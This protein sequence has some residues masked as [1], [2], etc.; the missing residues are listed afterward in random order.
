MENHLS[1]FLNPLRSRR[2]DEAE[3]VAG[4]EVRLLTSAATDL[5][6]AR[7]WKLGTPAVIV[8]LLAGAAIWLAGAWSTHAQL[9]L[10]GAE[11]GPALVSAAAVPLTGTFRSLTLMQPPFPFNP[12]PGLPVYVLADGTFI[13]D[14]SQV[15]YVALRTE[16]AAEATQAK[17]L[18]FSSSSV[19][20]GGG[21]GEVMSLSSSASPPP[22]GGGGG[23][24]SGGGGTGA[25]PYSVPGLKLVIPVL[26]NGLVLTSLMEADTNS[27]YDLFER[28]AFRSNSFWSRI[29]GTD[30]GGTNFAVTKVSTTNAFYLAADTTDS[31]FDGLSD[32]FETLVSKSNPL[33]QDTDGDGLPD[34]DEDFNGNGIPDRFDYARLKRA[35]IFA[36]RPNAF[37]GGQSGELT[38]LLPSPA[39]TNATP[40]TLHLGGNT[41]AGYDY[42]LTSANGVV[43]SNIV[44]FSAGQTQTN[45]FVVASN[46]TVQETRER[47]MQASLLEAPNFALSTEPAQV[48]LVDNDK[49][50]VSIL[51]TDAKAGETV[52]TIQNPG[53][54]TFI[55]EGKITN[56]LSVLVIPGGSATPGVDYSNLGSIDFPAGVD[57]VTRTISPS[58]DNI[59]EGDETVV[60]AVSANSFYSVN[61]LRASAQL[62]IKDA[63][64]P[65]VSFYIVDPILTEYG[66]K[67]ATVAI[68]RTGSTALPLDVRLVIGGTATGGST[69][70]NADYEALATVYTI[71]AGATFID[72][73]ARP[74]A[75]G[76]VEPVETITL[77]LRGSTAYTI[78]AFENTATL[79][80]DDDNTPQYSAVVLRSIGATNASYP[81][82]FEIRRL[83]RSAA[84]SLP[85]EVYTNATNRTYNYSASGNVSSLTNVVFTNYASV[86]RLNLAFA[87][88]QSNEVVFPTIGS[89]RHAIRTTSGTNF[90]TLTKTG[91]FI[92]EGETPQIAIQINRLPG[93]T[94]LPE[95]KVKFALSGPS[96]GFGLTNADHSLSNNLTFTIPAGVAGVA[97]SPIAYTDTQI[98]GWENIL[99][100][101]EVTDSALLVGSTAPFFLFV[102]DSSDN[103]INPINAPGTDT[104]GD[105]MTDYYE[106]TN[107]LDLFSAVD[108]PAD[109]DWDGLLNFEEALAGTKPT[110]TDS[111]LDGVDDYFETMQGSDPNSATD[112]GRV[113][114]GADYVGVKLFT[115]DTGKVNNGANCAVCH[116]TK[117]KVGDKS[118]Y[119]LT[120]GQASERT[121]QYAKGA[122]YPIWLIELSRSLPATTNLGD[123]P[124]T[125]G[126]YD[127]Y[128]LPAT[129]T[130]PAAFVV[131]DPNSKLGTNRPWTNFPADP[132]VSVATLIVPRIEVLWETKSGNTAL[133]ANTNTGRG[134]R[135]YP[136]ATSPTDNTAGRNVV[137][138]RVKTTPAVT[139]Y[140]V[141]LRWFDVDD[142]TSEGSDMRFVIDANDGVNAP[143]GNDNRG[144]GA[145]VAQTILTLDNTGQA[146]TDFDV[147]WQ[148]GDNFRIA[149]ILNTPGADT[150]INQLQ[151]TNA[152]AP[153]YVASGTNQ[154]A[155]FVG[156]LSPMLTVWRK[157]HL[158]FDSMTAPPATGPEAN[159]VS[160]TISGFRPNFP[161]SGRSHVAVV[162]GGMDDGSGLFERGKLEIAGVGTFAITNSWTLA[163]VNGRGG[164]TVEIFGAPGGLTN[165]QPVKLYDDD[166]RYLTNDPLYPSNLALQSPPLPATNQVAPFILA[167]QP[168][169]GAAYLTLVNANAQAGWNTTQIIPFKL[170]EPG[171]SI[172]GTVFD[173]GNLQLKG[174]DRPEFW[175]FSVVFG[176]QSDF[177]DDGESD[178][179]TP[180]SGGTPETR[181]PTIPEHLYIAIGYS[182]V[183]LENIRDYEFGKRF[184]S[185]P[186]PGDF[187]HSIKAPSLRDKYIQRLN[188]VIAHEIGHPPGRKSET[189]DHNEDDLM[190]TGAPQGFTKE[191]FAPKT[192]NRFR[193]ATRWLN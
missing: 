120:H 27:A 172:F 111:D 47:R 167:A 131:Q 21:G 144:G 82:Q 49:A 60:L 142:P 139:N 105:G 75:D 37:E 6:D 148:P 132:T 112:G 43:L 17:S 170:Q 153:M 146:V 177:T 110:W 89:T 54:F 76:G 45:L 8:A 117:L 67:P 100:T 11:S 23:G 114:S 159:F 12:F 180:L 19:L 94:E 184:P 147:S 135:I 3:R 14:D 83:G 124:L 32:A 157:L 116:T 101:P 125:S 143:R 189:D 181:V 22:P 42:N 182:A 161:A 62:T 61:P 80:L 10:A 96:I 141:R 176:Y 121:F 72:V 31:D 104:D 24:G 183:F 25:P 164:T 122:S 78:A 57:R 4:E 30:I 46:N 191:K 107:G 108:G 68:I 81:A 16:I 179:E 160:A 79:L 106:V 84:A 123:T 5:K 36:S 185:D 50:L 95:M 85:F 28:F 158:E 169:F 52:G 38:I 188:A 26:T 59:Y 88:K 55:R 18:Q 187:V 155:E 130:M 98:E 190:I 71:P 134:I 113:P 154:I 97:I 40:I 92:I 35:V 53:E 137:R 64:L 145:G 162:H 175:A 128:L 129:N 166:D 77:T 152:I 63:D 44:W 29:A 165:G 127:A 119:S 149:A 9:A 150:H 192:V 70:N 133:D 173:N 109:S 65:R 99:L 193:Q 138:V 33:L 151:V 118:T 171:Y 13:Y 168:K 87:T 15:D 126:K 7:P 156:A 90:F 1:R 140:P 74:L 93:L 56:A 91:D 20:L 66:L 2:G 69:N 163:Y 174:Q 86:A 103:W 34:G 51:A 136:D 115:R 102:G 58:T 73:V 39:P 41:D 178:E 186:V 48:T